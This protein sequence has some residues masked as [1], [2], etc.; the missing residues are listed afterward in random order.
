MNPKLKSKLCII[1]YFIIL[2]AVFIGGIF[3]FRTNDM[4][5]GKLNIELTVEKVKVED[6]ISDLSEFQTFFDDYLITLNKQCKNN[7]VND[8]Y[9]AGSYKETED[10]YKVV[11]HTRRVDKLGGLGKIA[12]G[13]SENY[14]EF[15]TN[16]ID[17]FENNYEGKIRENFSRAFPDGTK[18]NYKNVSLTT[19]YD[20]NIVDKG[21]NKPVELELAKEMVAKKGAH[22]IS[23]KLIDFDLVDEISFKVDGKFRFVSSLVN[24]NDIY[25]N[26]KVD[27]KRVGLGFHN[28]ELGA[29]FRKNAFVRAVYRNRLYRRQLQKRGLRHIIFGV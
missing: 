9:Q 1:G 21:T 18:A 26:I 20:I 11:V 27:G 24:G 4:R 29:R 2:V 7:T 13:L 12:Y 23:F 25:E 6:K 10:A 3:L 5:D 28:G 15:D 14:F 17:T 16:N 19:P 22:F 8:F